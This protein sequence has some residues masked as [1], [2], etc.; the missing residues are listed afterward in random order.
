MSIVMPVTDRTGWAA[1]RSVPQRVYRDDPY[2]VADETVDFDAVLIDADPDT[3]RRADTQ[4]FVAYDSAEPAAF[5]GFYEAVQ[6]DTVA[7][8]LLDAAASWARDRGLTH[9]YGPVNLS[10]TYGAGLLVSGHGQPALVGMPHN[11]EYYDDQLTRWGL[12]KTKDLHSYS[13]PVP[14]ADRPRGRAGVVNWRPMAGLSFRHLDPARFDEEMG[15]IR[16]IYNDA[17]VDFW[18]FTPSDP[19]EFARLAD[20]FRP[21]LDE[22]LVVFVE[23]DGRPIGYLMAFPD[24]NQV[25]ADGPPRHARIDMLA[26]HPDYQNT[27]VGAMLIFEMLRR[28][29]CKGYVSAEAAPILEDASWPRSL[30]GRALQLTRVYRVYGRPLEAA[31]NGTSAGG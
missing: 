12:S 31:R 2:W 9:L 29:H 1:F 27:W 13:F 8:G 6:R 11:P 19:A 3:R 15:M 7:F 24:I 4:A 18:G 20:G 21:V 16:R 30:R 28:L 22:E 23:V 25:A 10:M 17:F 5:F 14:R 26:V